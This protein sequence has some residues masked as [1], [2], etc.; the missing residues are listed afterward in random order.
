MPNPWLPHWNDPAV[1]FDH[2][3]RW[4]TAAEILAAQ[5]QTTKK[6]P[7]R[8]QAY[9][10]SRISD[11]VLWLAN[12]RNKL[13]GYQ[14]T[15]AL[16]EAETTACIASCNFTIYVLGDWLTA[17]RDFGPAATEAMDLLLTGTGPD[18]VALPVMDPPPLP[19]GVGPV[20]PGVLTRVFELVAIIKAAP[21]YNE[22]IGEDLGIIGSAATQHED[23]ATPA[24]KLHL[25]PGPACQAVK[26]TF[27]KYGHQGV[28]IECQRGTGAWEFVAVDSESPYL[29]ERP[30][31][32][33]GTPEVRKY[34]L[35]YWDKGTPN[36]D[37]S[38]VASI[39]V[40]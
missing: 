17:V 11:Q 19:T 33:P 32:V 23:Q 28:W 4:P 30:L 25:Q 40:A 3:W 6:G 13:P 27:K 8:R 21:G 34:R 38:D 29:D 31:L 35:R 26:I 1:R 12:F 24:F 2:G 9:Y 15:L 14:E 37:W 18:P 7:M 20:P 39:T 5:T 16:P 36:G 22:T 10:P